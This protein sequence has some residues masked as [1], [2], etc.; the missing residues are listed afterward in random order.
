MFWKLQTKRSIAANILHYAGWAGLGAGA[1]ALGPLWAVGGGLAVMGGLFVNSYKA[2]KDFFDDGLLAHPDRHE[3]SPNLKKIINNLFEKSGLQNHHVV[4]YD[5]KV[6]PKEIGAKSGVGRSIEKMLGKIAMT[7][8]AAAIN[9]GKPVVMISEPLLELLDDHEEEAVLAHEFAHIVAEHHKLRFPQIILKGAIKFTNIMTMLGQYAAAGLMGVCSILAASGVTAVLFKKYHPK[10]D[11]LLKNV[12]DDVPAHVVERLKDKRETI[13]K[14]ERAIKY[15]K[16]YKKRDDYEELKRNYQKEIERDEKIISSS[17]RSLKEITEIKSTQGLFSVFKRIVVTGVATAFNPAFAGYFAGV[18]AIGKT[19]LLLEKSYSRANE[20]QADAGAVTI[21]SNPLSLI[22]ALRK[23]TIIHKR[24]V[25]AA[26]DG[27]KPQ[28]GYLKKQWAKANST[29]PP[30]EQRIQR[31][32]VIA[33]NMG[34]SEKEIEHAVS[35]ELFVPD[36]INIPIEHIR[37]M[38]KAFLGPEA[39]LISNLSEN[40]NSYQGMKD[41]NLFIPTAQVA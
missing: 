1:I 2:N 31:L 30:L 35:G 19:A 32:A 41:K 4:I 15:G 13:K 5:F 29:H 39:D 6:K 37:G 25:E 12:E 8:N 27:E 33:R 10:G 22:T 20:F 11:L 23:I 16:L 7:P 36:H 28:I 17:R 40:G 3:F 38:A 34:I 14:I 21:G 26:W 24:S 18:F 9:L